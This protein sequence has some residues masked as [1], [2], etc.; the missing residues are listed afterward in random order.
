MIDEV[1]DLQPCLIYLLS[2]LAK[3]SVFFS[4]DTAQT[5][6]AGVN[7]KFEDVKKIFHQRTIKV[8]I[9]MEMP[10]NMQLTTSFRS[11][12]NILKIANSIVVIIEK[13][14]PK[15]IDILKKE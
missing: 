14:F 11:Q 1:Q 12:N 15:T 4:G 6:T 3:Q 5:I 2:S 10:I 9:K 13:L 8:P 7:F